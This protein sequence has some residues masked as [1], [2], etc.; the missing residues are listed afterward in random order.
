MTP[1]EDKQEG[2]RELTLQL[3]FRCSVAQCNIDLAYHKYVP[4]FPNFCSNAFFQR[5]VAASQQVQKDTNWLGVGTINCDLRKA[6]VAM[7]SIFH[8]ISD[9]QYIG[10]C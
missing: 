7:V 6:T 8:F 2:P 1:L 3:S 10:E 4:V 9:L 5:T